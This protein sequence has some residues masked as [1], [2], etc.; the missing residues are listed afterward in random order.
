MADGESRTTPPVGITV[1]RARLANPYRRDEVT[2]DV[3]MLVDTGAV[4]SVVPA[5]LLVPLG[6]V[7]LGEETFNLA[8]GTQRTYPVG[9]AFFAVA[10]RRATSKVVFGPVVARALLGALT[11]ESLGLMVDPVTRRLVPG[12]LILAR[13]S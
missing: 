13:A 12:P 6:I 2:V 10:E 7:P 3:E 4:Y 8:D 11:L 5:D 9:E 1:V